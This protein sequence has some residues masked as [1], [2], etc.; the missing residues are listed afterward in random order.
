AGLPAALDGLQAVIDC[1]NVTSLSRRTET[2]FFVAGTTNLTRAA[3]AAGVVHHV[4]LSIVGVDAVPMG[5]CR[6]KLAQER[7]LIEQAG[8]LKLPHSIVRTTQ[9]HEFA[10]QMLD[11]SLIGRW[12]PVPGMRIRPVDLADVSQRLIEVAT[13]RAAGRVPDLGGPRE[14]DLAELVRRLVA[15]R[16]ERVRVVRVPLP[17]RVGHSIRAGGLLP[18]GG[19]TGRRD[20]AEWLEDQPVENRD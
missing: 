5:Y 4:L 20:F 15:H 9:F 12:A 2:D 18:E 3:A 11:R 1:S 6:A 14:E 10:S 19:L 8:R 13:G 17:G 7:V 16:G